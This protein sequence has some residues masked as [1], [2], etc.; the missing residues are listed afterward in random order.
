MQQ[1]HQVQYNSVLKKC[2]Y[3]LVDKVFNEGYH[4]VFLETPTQFC[5]MNFSGSDLCCCF[6]GTVSRDSTWAPYEQAKTV[7][8]NFSFSRKYLFSKFKNRVS[9]QSTTQQTPNF[10]FRYGDFHTFYILLLDVYTFFCLIV[11]LK[12]VRNL[13]SFPKVAAQSLTT[14]TP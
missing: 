2:Y 13:Q 7:L 12:S 9:A 14:L 3:S 11:P 1:L 5:K 6:K 10:F 8:R 4:L